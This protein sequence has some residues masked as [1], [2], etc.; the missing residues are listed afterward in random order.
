MMVIPSRARRL[1][2]TASVLL[3]LVTVPACS[4]TECS[5]IGASNGF[6]VTINLPATTQ[7]RAT[8]IQTC[9][10][11]VC[12]ARGGHGLDTEKVVSVDND[13]VPQSNQVSVVV[14]LL[15]GP[16]LRLAGGKTEVATR[17]VQPNGPGCEPTVW[18]AHVTANATGL[19]PNA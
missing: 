16:G 19:T 12:Q 6:S 11:N 9:V 13:S 10:A 4:T 15:D 8:S 5:S 17:Q 18:I 7:S 3:A 2:V 14:R 1:T